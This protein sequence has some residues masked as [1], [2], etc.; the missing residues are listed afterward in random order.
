M[1]GI[2]DEEL[3]ALL[4]AQ[5]RLAA[6]AERLQSAPDVQTYLQWVEEMEGDARA[7]QAKATAWGQ[8]MDAAYP[9]AKVRGQIVVQLT[10]EQQARIKKDTGVAL[11]TVTIDDPSG[12][13]N[14]MMELAHPIDIYPY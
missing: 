7:L 1:P 12:S 13:L 6:K 11:E 14:M 2:Q 10:P 9:K 5:Q 8:K 4:E 3:K